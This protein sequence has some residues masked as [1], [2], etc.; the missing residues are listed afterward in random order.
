MRLVAGEEVHELYWIFGSV[1]WGAW[2]GSPLRNP[3]SWGSTRLQS[4][5]VM[6]RHHFRDKMKAGQRFLWKESLT[7]PV[8]FGWSW[9]EALP[10]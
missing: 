9:Y 8:G 1:P 6:G 3:W 5:T 2:L 4:I 7:I 10:L